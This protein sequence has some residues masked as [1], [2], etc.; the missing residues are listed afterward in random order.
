MI[1]VP[2]L[3][4]FIEDDPFEAN[5]QMVVPY[6][7]PSSISCYL[8]CP[9]QFRRE[10][11]LRER[12]APGAWGAAGSA[13]HSARRDALEH[14]LKTGEAMSVAELEDMYALAWGA[15]V[16]EEVNWRDDT[17]GTVFDAGLAMTVLYHRELGSKIRPLA[18]EQS[19]HAHVPGV[20]VPLYGRIDVIDGA[21]PGGEIVDTKTGKQLFHQINPAHYIQGMVYVY[22]LRLPIRWHSVSQKP[23][24]T[25]SDLLRLEPRA[26]VLASAERL[27]RQA[28]LGILYH[29]QTFGP[30]EVWTGAGM[31]GGACRYCSFRAS[32][33]HVPD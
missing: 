21:V 22:A 15:E 28:Y 6:L 20:P 27:T 30:E 3:R 4:P 1:T 14:A 11:V 17:P 7:S 31:A 12:R 32:C 18:I 33:A 26:K 5:S 16:A 9:E 24:A 8:R 25:T 10:Y 2:D 23:A 29:Q 19:I 13:F